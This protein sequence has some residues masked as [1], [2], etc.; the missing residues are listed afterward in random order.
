[1][2]RSPIAEGGPNERGSAEIVFPFVRRF[3]KIAIIGLNSA[4]YTPPFVAAGRLGDEQIERL[5][6]RLDALGRDGMIRIVLIHHPPLPG[7]AKPAKALEDAA[8]LEGVLERYGAELVIHGHNHLSTVVYRQSPTGPVPI[9]GVPSASLALPHGK[10]PLARYH[11]YRI[12][13]ADTGVQIELVARGLDRVG[14][15]VVEIERCL[16]RAPP[17]LRDVGA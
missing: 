7:L 5:S 3:D 10:E 8:A 16:L 4:K 12:T 14:G 11:L 17:A 6:E 9:V 15:G 13:P 2:L 1:M